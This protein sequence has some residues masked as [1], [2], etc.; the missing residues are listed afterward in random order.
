MRAPCARLSQLIVPCVNSSA[1]TDSHPIHRCNCQH[2]HH[3]KEHPRFYKKKPNKPGVCVQAR[4]LVPVKLNDSRRGTRGTQVRSNAQ[5]IRIAVYALHTPPTA[6]H[7]CVLVTADCAWRCT[8]QRCSYA[9]SSRL[10][11]QMSISNLNAPY[12]LPRAPASPQ[13]QLQVRT[14]SLQSARRIQRSSG[15]DPSVEYSRS[16]T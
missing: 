8:L 15:I 1:T 14:A 9:H 4:P 3:Y 6:A 10:V 2:F 7:R 13:E 12:L 16:P 5:H 11:G